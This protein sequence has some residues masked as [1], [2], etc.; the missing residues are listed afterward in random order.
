MEKRGQVSAFIIGGIVIL[1]FFL[2][3]FDAETERADDGTEGFEQSSTLFD[4]SI[5]HYI[6][7]CLEKITEEAI[8]HN[9]Q[10]GVILFYLPSQQES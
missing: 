9:A 5:K 4:T 6:E 3:V 7:A 8:L 2:L 10:Q 1:L